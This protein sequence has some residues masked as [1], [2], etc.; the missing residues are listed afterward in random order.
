MQVW[1]CYSSS[2]HSDRWSDGRLAR[3]LRNLNARASGPESSTPPMIIQVQ[4]VNTTYRA[5]SGEKSR[6]KTTAISENLAMTIEA[7]NNHTPRGGPS[8][9]LS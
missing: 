2:I 6:A 4:V 9:S 5:L 7:M 1:S 3:T 8:E